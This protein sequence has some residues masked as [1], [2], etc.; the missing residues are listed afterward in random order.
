MSEMSQGAAAK[1]AKKLD[2]GHDTGADEGPAVPPP[3]PGGQRWGLVQAARHHGTPGAF[4]QRTRGIV[5]FS[6][7]DNDGEAPR[8][9]LLFRVMETPAAFSPKIDP[10]E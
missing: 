5:L 8:L 1:G 4:E 7:N 3:E 2:Q 9:A 10:S 6:H